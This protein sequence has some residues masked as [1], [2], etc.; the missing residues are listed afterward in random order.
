MSSGAWL[1]LVSSP[2]SSVYTSLDIK[3][4]PVEAIAV[5]T[6]PAVNFEKYTSYGV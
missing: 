3:S 1:N 6:D 2:R 5:F 4:S